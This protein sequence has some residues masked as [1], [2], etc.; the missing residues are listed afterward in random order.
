M[1]S[2]METW[3]VGITTTK[4]KRHGKLHGVQ[5]LEKDLMLQWTNTLFLSVL[6]Y[7]VMFPLVPHYSFKTYSAFC[8]V[9]NSSISRSLSCSLEPSSTRCPFH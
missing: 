1:I 8:L 9:P 2:N 7:S 6:F 3:G 4:L 5:Q